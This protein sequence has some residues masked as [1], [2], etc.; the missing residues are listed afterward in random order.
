MDQPLTARWRLIQACAEGTSHQG[1]GVPCQDS[2]FSDV[3]EE[4]GVSAI[5]IAVADGAGSSRYGGEGAEYACV[6]AFDSAARWATHSGLAAAPSAEQLS[7]WAAHVHDGLEVKAQEHGTPS[8]EFACTLLVSVC[9]PSW[10]AFLQIGDG[11]IVVR[12]ALG[13]RPVFWPDAGEYAN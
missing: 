13:L 6:A 2:C 1:T 4:G 3:V 7:A 12:D 11:V 5:V 9:T 10:S 8:R